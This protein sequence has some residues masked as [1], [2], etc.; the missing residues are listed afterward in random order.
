MHPPEAESTLPQAE[1]DGRSGRWDTIFRQFQRAYVLKATVV[2]FFGREKCTPDK[3]LAT[4]RLWG[5]SKQV[6]LAAG[7]VVRKLELAFRT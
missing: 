4:P 3:I 7:A 2:N 5:F 1:Q 6:G